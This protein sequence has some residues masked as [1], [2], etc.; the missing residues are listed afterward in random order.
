[1]A[2]VCGFLGARVLSAVKV[3]VGTCL[4]LD[5]RQVL[6]YNPH[7][8]REPSIFLAALCGKKNELLEGWRSGST[9]GA[10]T[11]RQTR[12]RGNADAQ[13]TPR[14][15]STP[16]KTERNNE[17][18]APPNYIK[19]IGF[20]TLFFSREWCAKNRGKKTGFNSRLRL[21]YKNR[22][23]FNWRYTAAML[24]A[25]ARTAKT[26]NDRRRQA[27]TTDDGGANKPTGKHIGESQRVKCCDRRASCANRRRER[28][29]QSAED[30][31]ITPGGGL[32]GGWAGLFFRCAHGFAR[33]LF[34][35]PRITPKICDG[36]V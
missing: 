13:T 1:M 5:W 19:L 23:L 18:N 34:G 26:Q 30:K 21:L 7:D 3:A 25:T 16:P 2:A 10:R 31:P 35:V 29:A 14:D 15:R 17:N 4:D 9:E 11:R 32:G 8:R 22:V 27:R 20:Y 33:R 28:D 12:R 24:F 36:F 6:R